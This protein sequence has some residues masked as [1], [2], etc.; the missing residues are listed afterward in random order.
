MVWKMKKIDDDIEA[1][2]GLIRTY[3]GGGN[4]KTAASFG[5]AMR[6]VS[7]G[8]KVHVIQ[9]LKSNVLSEPFSQ[10]EK[11]LTLFKI[12][13]FGQHCPFIDILKNN[14]IRC[15]ECRKCH[16]NPKNPKN[17]DFE[18]AE[19]A[20]E[21]AFGVARSG[22]Y[23]MLV[24]D[25]VLRA[26]DLG[27]VKLELLLSFLKEKPFSLDLIL[28]GNK[29]PREIVELSDYVSY[30]VAVKRPGHKRKNSKPSLDF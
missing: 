24:L 19:M 8:M 7:L 1:N 2:R 3:I 20:F 27:L 28:T 6:A 30:I 23:D 15:N 11:N 25:E 29:A 22:E 21:M 13:S 14:L 18:F 10:L 12:D 4:G 5:M 17:M 16:V 26:L 9:F